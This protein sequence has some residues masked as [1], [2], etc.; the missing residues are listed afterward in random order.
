MP[1][2]RSAVLN[3]FRESKIKVLIITNILAKVLDN[4][5][6]GLVINLDIPRGYAGDTN[7]ADC[8][9]Y[10]S[11]VRT[12]GMYGDIGVAITLYDKED[13]GDLLT[14]IE[15]FNDVKIKELTN[16]DTDREFDVIND[17]LGKVIKI[18]RKKREDNKER[19][20][21]E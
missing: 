12:Q 10:N 6:I 7:K 11:R 8:E 5:S 18:N 21:K 16:E 13:E 2:E 19:I 15:K 9:A 20:L 3:S 1:H 4:K 17:M 14:Q